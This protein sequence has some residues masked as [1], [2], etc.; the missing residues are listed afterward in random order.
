MSSVAHLGV[1]IVS[2]RGSA[3]STVQASKVLLHWYRIALQEV[4]SE[5]LDGSSVW[6]VVAVDPPALMISRPGCLYLP[7]RNRLR[8]KDHL[9]LVRQ[10]I[11]RLSDRDSLPNSPSPSK[12]GFVSVTLFLAGS[13]GRGGGKSSSSVIRLG[14]GAF[15]GA[16]SG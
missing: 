11:R 2:Q 4:P 16:K 7:P 5:A 12:A 1:K 14:G 6:A 13:T 8:R 3:H 15:L 9:G 10:M